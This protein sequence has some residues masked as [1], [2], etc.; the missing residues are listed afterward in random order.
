MKLNKATAVALALLLTAPSSAQVPGGKGSKSNRASRNSKSSKSAPVPNQNQI[1]FSPALLS[2]PPSLSPSVSA[3]PSVYLRPSS[4]PSKSPEPSGAPS[5]TLSEQPSHQALPDAFADDCVTDSERC[6]FYNRF[7][8]DCS[9][10]FFIDEMETACKFAHPAFDRELT[11]K[12]HKAC[13]IL[14]IEELGMPPECP[15]VPVTAECGAAGDGAKNIVTHIHNSTCFQGCE[16]YRC[17]VAAGSGGLECDNLLVAPPLGNLLCNEYLTRD[18]FTGRQGFAEDQCRAFCNAYGSTSQN[19][20]TR[21]ADIANCIDKNCAYLKA[22]A[23]DE[24]DYPPFSGSCK[25]PAPYSSSFLI[26]F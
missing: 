23:I 3:A 10:G 4:A 17:L 21:A 15:T 12:G 19:D 2:D 16:M 6:Q 7:Q 1:I 26:S 9:S 22:L 24:A 11:T 25:K 5:E 20:A 13:V 18:G 14:A 8:P